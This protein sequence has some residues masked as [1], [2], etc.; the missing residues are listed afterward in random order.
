MFYGVTSD[1]F[2]FNK[3]MSNLTFDSEGGF[4]IWLDQFFNI[5]PNNFW[6]GRINK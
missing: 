6:Q 1:L 2:L 3:E 5:K 4:E